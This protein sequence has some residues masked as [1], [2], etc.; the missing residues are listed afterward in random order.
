MKSIVVFLF[1]VISSSVFS[2][3]VCDNYNVYGDRIYDEI[4]EPSP[5]DDV[6][7]VRLNLIFMQKNDGS[8]NF[9]E[10]NVEHQEFLD[11]VMAELNRTFGYLED[12]HDVACYTG[13]DFISDTKIRFV[14][15]RIYIRDEYGWNNAND[16]DQESFRPDV[17]DWYLNYINDDIFNDASIPKGINVFYTNNSTAYETVIGASSNPG[18]NTSCAQFPTGVDLA[19]TSKVH[20][21]DQFVKYLH[22]FH[23]APV[24][25][26]G[27]WESGWRWTCFHGLARGLAHELGHSLCLNHRCPY[28]ESKEC[29]ESIMNPNAEARTYIP[30]SEIGRMHAA[31]SFTNLR[32]FVDEDY[33]NSNT[34]VIRE[35]ITMPDNPRFYSDIIIEN[36]ATVNFCDL[37]FPSQATITIKNGSKMVLN[38]SLTL[39]NDNKIIIESGGELELTP[40]ADILVENEGRIE[41]QCGGTLDCQAIIPTEFSHINLSDAE[42]CV[43]EYAGCTTNY[44]SYYSGSNPFYGSGKRIQLASDKTISTITYYG[45]KAEGGR[46]VTTTGT[47]KVQSGKLDVYARE[48]IFD[49]TFEVSPGAEAE[50]HM[51]TYD[52]D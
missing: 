38:G 39:S 13:N 1:L 10:N 11:D 25:Y 42:S 43:L 4:F 18:A 31:L 51:D 49:G 28:Y 5:N 40:I 20:M 27:T 6:I 3:I 21:V 29:T 26:G 35:S 15:N 52:C 30:P 48:V 16:A 24:I 17:E 47:V 23:N 36:G 45:D 44:W 14:D 19:R 50:F 46:T 8:G 2:Q 7:I 41:V 33:Y 22:L 37:L 9:Q 34:F 12:P 32:N